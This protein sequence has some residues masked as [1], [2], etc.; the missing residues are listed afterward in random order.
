LAR[1]PY[2]ESDVAR[3]F[4]QKKPKPT[5]VGQDG[6]PK[7][8]AAFMRKFGMGNLANF[9]EEQGGQAEKGQVPSMF[10]GMMD[11][12]GNLTG[13]KPPGGF[14][15][16]G[17]SLNVNALSSA[18]GRAEILKTIKPK[19]V[20]TV[21]DAGG[22]T[23]Q[24]FI[25]AAP[26]AMFSIEPDRQPD[27]GPLPL[28]NE[29]ELF[30]SY[31][32]VFAF[33]CL[34][35]DEVN[36]PDDTYIKNGLSD[37]QIVFRS[38]TG[39]SA[40]RKPRTAAEMRYGIDTQYFI[41]NVE[42]DTWI[43]PNKKSRQTNF[44]QIRFEVREPY[45][46]GMLLQTMQLAALNAGYKNYLEAPWLLE[47]MFI[48]W[49]DI[50]KSN[51]SAPSTRKLLPLKVVSVEFN[52]DSEGSVYQFL[53]SAFNDEAFA[54][55]AQSISTDIQCS[56]RT[57][58]EICQS[59]INSIA[60]NLNTHKLKEHLTDEKGK[61][62]ALKDAGK[63]E[64]DEYIIAFPS[65]RA[66]KD[67]AELY[68]SNKKGRDTATTG[69]LEYK[70]FTDEETLEIVETGD[71]SLSTL[72][73]Q[74]GREY[75]TKFAR[76]KLIEGRLGYSIR[77]GTLSE[78]IK[79]VITD[80]DMGIN[81]IG[82]AKIAPEEPTGGGNADFGKAT[83]TYD[84]RTENFTRGATSIDPTKR[85][86]Q[87]RSGT[88]I[89]RILE[90]LVL[91]SDW[92]KK[93]L[94]LEPNKEGMVPWFKIESQMYLIHD[95]KAEAKNGRMPRIYV[96]NVVPYDVHIGS[97]QKPNSPPP[98]YDKLV[99]Q[100]VKAYNYMYTGLNK[101]ILD[102]EIKLDNTFFSAINKMNGKE[103]N[104]VANKA[105]DKDVTEVSESQDGGEPGQDGGRKSQSEVANDS[106]PLSAGAI[107]ETAEIQVARAFN[108]AIVRSEAD[109]ITLNMRILGDPY[110]IAD[111]G[112]GNFNS[113]PTE[114]ININANGSMDHQRGQVDVIINFKTPI[115]IDPEIGNYKMQAVPISGIDNFSGLYQVITVN[116]RIEN[117][118]FTQELSMVK[119]P[120]FDKKNIAESNTKKA[121][122][123]NKEAEKELR[124]LEKLG[125]SKDDDMYK[126]KQLEVQNNLN[127][128]SLG[129][130]GISMER[131]TKL[132]AEIKDKLA[133][134]TSAREKINA[135]NKASDDRLIALAKGRAT[136]PTGNPVATP[137][138]A[139]DTSGTFADDAQASS[140][141]SSAPTITTG[142][143][144]EKGL[145]VPY[146]ID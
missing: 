87:F 13:V 83:F 75:A 61:P 131:A 35:P 43:A 121:V 25:N 105:T 40:P 21:G 90:E 27:D 11:N 57:L 100:A 28:A 16:L 24:D 1:D 145:W 6:D 60:T 17:A 18:E 36:Y 29:L 12:K 88:K 72:F 136:D 59:G 130:I 127:N 9:Y 126:I 109:L 80:K 73:D 134:D 45:S 31:S 123:I 5:G 69:E 141:G 117:N 99:K 118:V 66:S 94:L 115:D 37:G 8:A 38:G 108:E 48:G 47:M 58:E 125:V 10:G 55:N 62:I 51:P 93:L 20:A 56:G 26:Q 86:I 143:I 124:Q 46:M 106:V 53:C 119:R 132:Q 52:V 138:K 89:Q 133:A 79:K 34:S 135:Q 146:G 113:A 114:Y 102:F 101:D 140:S 7:V 82:L 84:K 15:N 92:G 68:S 142:Y 49:K 71:V 3:K 67:Q 128:I 74:A 110:Y 63:I 120:N 30:A 14:G 139:G 111:S 54:D 107:A 65:K 23:A 50:E 129:Q 137:P 104:D 78:S 96:Y 41:N 97:F 112:M 81:P 98:G 144:D 42:I 4:N 103:S 19:N 122:E 77:R 39:L 33:G 85:T 116:N 95:S 2:G 70:E 32:N 64:V 44:H 22:P 91:I 76:R